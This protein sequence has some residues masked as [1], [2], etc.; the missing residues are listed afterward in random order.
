M[1]LHRRTL[2]VSYTNRRWPVL[3]YERI[4]Y[5]LFRNSMCWAFRKTL[6]HWWA[7]LIFP[8]CWYILLDNIKKN[9]TLTALLISTENVGTLLSPQWQM[10][11]SQIACFPP[12]AQVFPCFPWCKRFIMYLFKPVW[13]TSGLT[14][15]F[16]KRWHSMEKTASV[17]DN[18]QSDKSVLPGDNPATSR[19]AEMPFTNPHSHVNIHHGKKNTQRAERK[20]NC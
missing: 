18:P 11:V 9:H 2:P 4:F 17:A 13:V 8:E 10:L 1:K 14:S 3:Q 19:R 12:K 20:W 16:Q 5:L 15:Y 6:I 7:I